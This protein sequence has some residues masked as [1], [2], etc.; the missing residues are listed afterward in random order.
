MDNAASVVVSLLI[1]AVIIVA[2]WRLFEKAGQAGWK[3]LI[4]LYNA[5]ILLKIV[6]RPGWWLV[7]YLIPIVNF[8]IAIVVMLDLAKSFGR[9]AAFGIGLL[10]LSFIFVPILAFG[11]SQYL[12]P[13]GRPGMAG[14][15]VPRT[16]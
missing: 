7:L 8:V 16:V 9:S 12:G 1:A 10:L 14:A 6:G 3:S 15:G 2:Y 5:Y 11:T 4:P 13:G